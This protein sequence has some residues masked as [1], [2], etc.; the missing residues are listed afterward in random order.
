[1]TPSVALKSCRLRPGGGRFLWSL[2]MLPVFQL[3]N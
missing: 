1:M 3:F 2:F